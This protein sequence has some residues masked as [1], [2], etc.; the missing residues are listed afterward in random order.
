M[1]SSLLSIQDHSFII[2]EPGFD[3][4]LYRLTEQYAELSNINIERLQRYEGNPEQMIKAFRTFV[5]PRMGKH[6]RHLGLKECILGNWRLYP[7]FFPEMKYVVLARD[8]RDVMLSVLEYG[9][10]IKWHREMWADR[11]D[12]YIAERHNAIWA[13]QKEMLASRDCLGVKYEHLCTDETTLRGI[14]RHCEMETDQ[15]GQADTAVTE[16]FQW[17][18]WE[19][20]RHGNSVSPKSVSRWQRETDEQKLARAYAVAGMMTEY[21][22]YWGYTL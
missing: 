9:E 1:L 14:L 7:K 11:P 10:R 20:K 13:G 15:L 4:G 12:T 21:C 6:F 16:L 2:N 5:A 22:G 8:P 18:D 3:R 19:G 17:R